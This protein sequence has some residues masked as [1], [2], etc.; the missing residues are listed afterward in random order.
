MYQ[1][2]S[3][4][5]QQ[6]SILIIGTSGRS[7]QNFDWVLTKKIVVKMRLLSIF[8]H[9]WKFWLGSR[10]LMTQ[11]GSS[12]GD[13]FREWESDKKKAMTLPLAKHT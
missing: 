5:K 8:I 6:K 1:P 12:T 13:Y 3:T 4:K 7:K 10:N 2:V 11:S 9:F